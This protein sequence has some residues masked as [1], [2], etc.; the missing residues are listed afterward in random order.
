MRSL[1][2]VRN[3]GKKGNKVL[4]CVLL[5]LKGLGWLPDLNVLLTRKL[6]VFVGF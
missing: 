2:C 6:P 3:K 5:H 4:L 1:S